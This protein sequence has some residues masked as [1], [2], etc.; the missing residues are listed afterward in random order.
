M[1][2]A[3]DRFTWDVHIPE[4][5]SFLDLSRVTPELLDEVSEFRGRV[6][7]DDGRR[8]EFR[9]AGQFLDRDNYDKF[10]FHL[11][12]RCDRTLIGYLRVIRLKDNSQCLIDRLFG[13]EQYSGL[14][15]RLHTARSHCLEGGR[16]IVD[17]GW[18]GHSLGRQLLF[19][20]WAL[21]RSIG[22]SHIFGAAGSRDGQIAMI[23]RAGG[24]VADIPP[25]HVPEYADE[26]RVVYF[27]LDNPP[28][29]VL[30]QLPA[31]LRRLR[32][33]G[34]DHKR[35]SQTL[36]VLPAAPQYVGKEPP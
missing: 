8:P 9:H 10:A 34:R 7:Y 3:V 19:A 18:Q 4:S 27:E 36:S 23:Q 32:L 5:E 2:Q 20:Y 15:A 28:P 1:T 13:T 11:T 29:F 6:L 31:T 26:L 21:A 22:G 25:Q 30:A 24:R 35:P 17:R 14:I 12:V 16:W 33:A